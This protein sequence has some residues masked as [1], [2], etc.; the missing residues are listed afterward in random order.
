MLKY[1]YMYVEILCKADVT[2]SLRVLCSCTF[3][4]SFMLKYE[5]HVEIRCDKDKIKFYLTSDLIFNKH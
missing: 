5:I 1:S 3:V 2:E 4:L